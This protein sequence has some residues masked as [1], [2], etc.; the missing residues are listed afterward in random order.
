MIYYSI[1]SEVQ[2][3]LDYKQVMVAQFARE[4]LLNGIN[5][6]LFH[7]EPKPE[8]DCK[9]CAF[10]FIKGYFCVCFLSRYMIPFNVLNNKYDTLFARCTTNSES[11]KN[12]LYNLLSDPR[13]C[14]HLWNILK[15]KLA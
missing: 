4:K 5:K 11:K 3:I 7:S 14:R 2:K 1:T 8:L 15:P 9:R 10:T 12:N 6:V 13:H